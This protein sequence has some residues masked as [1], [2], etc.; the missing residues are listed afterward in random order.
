MV[1]H[2]QRVTVG[3][4]SDLRTFGIANIIGLDQL[5]HSPAAAVKVIG[6]DIP[7]ASAIHLLPHRQ[8]VAVSIQSDL[9]VRSISNIIGLNQLGCSPGAAFK[10]IGPNAIFACAIILGLHR[11]TPAVGIQ[12][13]LR[14]SN[15]NIVSAHPNLFGC[16]P[17]AISG[18]KGPG[19]IRR[20]SIAAKIGN[21]GG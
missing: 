12:S 19:V 13:D 18:G 15:S 7:G 16:F 21:L 6:P 14:I 9:G 10:A 20:H 5:G 1:P 2:R 8:R 3:I 11:Q 17:G 4:Q